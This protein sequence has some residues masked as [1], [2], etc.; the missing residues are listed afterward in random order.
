MYIKHYQL[1]KDPFQLAPDPDFLWRH[2]NHKEALSVLKKGIADDHGFLLLIGD[3][4]TGKTMLVQDL[5]ASQTSMDAVLVTLP[6]S[7]SSSMDFYNLL[8]EG[9]KMNRNFG[10]KGSFLIHFRD[11]LYQR[12][13]NQK[14]ILLI[15]DDSQSLTHNL[16]EDLRVLSYIEL[17][18]CRLISFLFVGRPEFNAIVEAPQNNAI[19]ERIGVR[20]NLAPLKHTEIDDY[21][22]HRLQKAGVTQPLFTSQAVQSVFT[23]TGGVPK[24]INIL[25]AEALRTG[26]TLGVHQINADIVHKSAETLKISPQSETPKMV[27]ALDKSP[28]RKE[29]IKD[30]PFT[31]GSP[32]K[33]NKTMEKGPPL[34][35]ADPK[36]QQRSA[37]LKV[38]IFGI[39]LLLIAFA[40]FTITHLANRNRLKWGFE[41]LISK[42][43]V[44]VLEKEKELPGNASDNTGTPAQSDSQSSGWSAGNETADSQSR[45]DSSGTDPLTQNENSGEIEP[46][47]LIGEKFIIHFTH[48]S[49]DV[50]EESYPTLDRI[51]GYMTDHSDAK[52]NVRGYTD[53]SGPASYNESVSMF[54][55]NTV[56]YYLIGRGVSADRIRTFGMGDANPV[57]P[58]TSADG[59]IQNRRVE[60]EFQDK[61]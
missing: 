14:K 19:A 24:R 26:S 4:G 47:P 49:N 44:T 41:G 30:P 55:A 5:L 10:S 38:F 23:W 50:E 37:A 52:I 12:R 42:K 15:I 13:A 40:G 46:L 1:Q 34:S 6:Q 59:R 39:L 36:T 9:F 32:S 27:R 57:A 3:E 33:E 22:R 7:I 17:N 21:I 48:N 51:A 45:H 61:R 35:V 28:A 11:I 25:C 16:M 60:I 53:S 2:A 31:L 58:N 43:H 56:K 54:R 29:M 20:H 8:A 18:E